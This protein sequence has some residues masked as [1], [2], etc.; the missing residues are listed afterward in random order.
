MFK[1]VLGPS[2]VVCWGVVRK[3]FFFYG[4]MKH[5]LRARAVHFC[6][7]FCLLAKWRRRRR[8]RRCGGWNVVC[9]VRLLGGG[10]LEGRGFRGFVCCPSRTTKAKELIVLGPPPL[11]MDD[12]DMMR[13]NFFLLTF[14]RNFGVWGRSHEVDVFCLFVC[15][16]VRW[17]WRVGF[18]GNPERIVPESFEVSD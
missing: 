12:D 17:R 11:F 10:M 3:V 14:C 15:S 8:R 13:R 9:V 2:V 18:F 6:L 5:L 4:R 16:W 7:P 1:R